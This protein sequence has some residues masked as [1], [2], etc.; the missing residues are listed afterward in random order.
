MRAREVWFLGLMTCIVA[1]GGCTDSS[2]PALISYIDPVPAVQS[3][4]SWADSSVVVLEDRGAI[5]VGPGWLSIDPQLAGVVLLDLDDSNHQLIVPGGI[6]P[7][8]NMATHCV[9]ALSRYVSGSVVLWRNGVTTTLEEPLA[10][11]H[12]SHLCINDDGTMLAW[13][14]FGTDHHS[15]IWIYLLDTRLYRYIGQGQDPQW[16]HGSNNLIYHRFGGSVH[17]GLVEYGCDSGAEREIWPF[18]E[19]LGGRD[20]SLSPDGTRMCFMGVSL[21]SSKCGLYVINLEDLSTSQINQRFGDG[22][23]WGPRGILYGSSCSIEDTG[24]CGVIWLFDPKTGTDA[25]LTH[26]FQFGIHE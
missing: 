4:A 26:R 6:F 15:G 8:A 12:R 1:A 13:R 9:V 20:F 7:H 23:S 21:Q 14:S 10:W 5:A 19:D 18:P 16:Q 11:E 24:D 3:G 22:T 25:P 17:P 2:Q